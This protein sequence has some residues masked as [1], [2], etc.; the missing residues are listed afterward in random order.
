VCFV[1]C[2]SGIITVS[3]WRMRLYCCTMHTYFGG[4]CH[5]EKIL[6]GGVK[7]FWHRSFI[8]KFCSHPYKWNVNNTGTKNGSLWNKRHF[9]EKSGECAA[10]LKYSVFIVVD[11][12]YKYI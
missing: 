9:E 3:L 11:K 4:N 1:F 2:P 8:F 7:T 10:C 12:K 6:K 5:I